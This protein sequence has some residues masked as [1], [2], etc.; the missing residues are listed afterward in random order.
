[1]V[2]SHQY[3]VYCK[4]EVLFKT[5]ILVLLE[6]FQFLLLIAGIFETGLLDCGTN[7]EFVK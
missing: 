7:Q 6:Y 2:A 5:S 3:A 1:M 4:C